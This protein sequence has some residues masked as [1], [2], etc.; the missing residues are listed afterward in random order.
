MA[1]VPADQFIYLADQPQLAPILA[2]WFYDEWGRG[3]PGSSREKMRR[4]LR[5]Y[6]NKDKIPLTIVLLRNS[7]PVASAS[8]KI[9]EMETH[10]QYLHWLGGVFVHPEYR[11]QGIGS[12]LVEYTIG[13]AQRLKVEDLYL[14]TRSHERFYKMLGWQV[15]ERPIY[16]GRITILMKRRLSVKEGKEIT[17]ENK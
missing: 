1:D 2:D 8:L 16:D 10:P 17:N 15:I 11:Q 4:N 6:L 7:Q 12:R 9:R 13:E 3:D 5:K 14:Y